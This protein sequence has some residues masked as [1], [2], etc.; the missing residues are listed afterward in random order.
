[1][2]ATLEYTRAYNTHPW[3]HALTLSGRQCQLLLL[4]YYNFFS[5]TVA[6]L[7]PFFFFFFFCESNFWG[8]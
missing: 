2:A 5:I 6:Q 7:L 4:N 3:S 1:M 8:F